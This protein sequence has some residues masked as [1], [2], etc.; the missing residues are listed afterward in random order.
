[1]VYAL[2]LAALLVKKGIAK[3]VYDG[4]EETEKSVIQSEAM[5]SAKEAYLA[6]LFILTVDKERYGGVVTKHKFSDFNMYS[7]QKLSDVKHSCHNLVKQD[8]EPSL[9]AISELQQFT[10]NRLYHRAVLRRN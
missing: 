3:E 6:C 2:H 5:K 1:M 10:D 4:M 9:L 8:N 7:V